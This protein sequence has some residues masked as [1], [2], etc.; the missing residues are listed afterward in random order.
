MESRVSNAQS[1]VHKGTNETTVEIAK[2]LIREAR[3][4]K[5]INGDQ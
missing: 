2:K 4:E 3:E 1:A 5:A